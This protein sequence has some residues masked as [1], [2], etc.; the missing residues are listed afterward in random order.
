MKFQ[1][2]MIINIF[3]EFVDSSFIFIIQC[4]EAEFID[5]MAIEGSL[6]PFNYEVMTIDPHRPVIM[7]D[8]KGKNLL[9]QLF[10]MFHQSKEF[11]KSSD[12]DS[13]IVC[14]LAISNVECSSAA[15]YFTD[16][17]GKVYP[18]CS[19]KISNNL[20]PELFYK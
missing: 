12:G 20:K 11:N 13:H 5:Q 7:Q 15:L 9:V 2:I 10:L 1:H 6:V 16:E 19:Y 14:I 18:C 17:E 3:D 4:C 8:G